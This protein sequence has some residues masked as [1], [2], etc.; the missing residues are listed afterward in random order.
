MTTG[1]AL[2]RALCMKGNA[3]N[4]ANNEKKDGNAFPETVS[5][6]NN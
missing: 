4:R 6:I 2:G 3:K 5:E 1:Y